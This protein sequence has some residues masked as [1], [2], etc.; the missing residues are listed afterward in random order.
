MKSDL[1]KVNYRV[2]DLFAAV[3]F[4]IAEIA[5]LDFGLLDLAILVDFDSLGRIELV[6]ADKAVLDNLVAVGHDAEYT[7]VLITY[8]CL[9]ARNDLIPRRQDRLLYNFPVKPRKPEG[10]F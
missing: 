2:P 4:E 8:I 5:A 9:E 10:F 6:G 3:V 7:V 1:F